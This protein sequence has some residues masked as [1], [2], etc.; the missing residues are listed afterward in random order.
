M[1]AV[2]LALFSKKYISY[3]RFSYDPHSTLHRESDLLLCT[4][5]KAFVDT[6]ERRNGIDLNK[7]AAEH[8]HRCAEVKCRTMQTRVSALGRRSTSCRNDH[9]FSSSCLCVCVCVGNR[10][11]RNL[12]EHARRNVFR[13]RRPV[14]TF[15]D[16]RVAS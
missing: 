14:L 16:D 12:P 9:R 8:Q 11:V 13:V 7:F 15:S 1:H 5:K 10:D 4:A 6:Q 2:L 3:R